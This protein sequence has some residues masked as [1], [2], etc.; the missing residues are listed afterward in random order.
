VAT[1]KTAFAWTAFGLLVV[2]ALLGFT[3]LI[4]WLP[5][6]RGRLGTGGKVTDALVGDPPSGISRSRSSPGTACSP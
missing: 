3:M 2:I 1:D 5:A 6:Y 4:R